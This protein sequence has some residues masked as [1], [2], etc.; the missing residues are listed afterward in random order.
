M[1]K[2]LKPKTKLLKKK[3]SLFNALSF[4]LIHLALDRD[5]LI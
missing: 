5:M 4:G 1:H 2:T 3:L